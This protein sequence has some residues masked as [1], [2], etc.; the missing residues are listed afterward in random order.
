VHYRSRELALAT[1]RPYLEQ[2]PESERT[3]LIAK[4]AP[5]FFRELQESS[6]ESDWQPQ[7]TGILEK[8]AADLLARYSGKT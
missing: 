8:T 1:F 3:E 5:D 2:L 4:M 7:A 6:A